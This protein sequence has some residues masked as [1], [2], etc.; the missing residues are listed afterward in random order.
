VDASKPT[1]DEP[2][3]APVL[4]TDREAARLCGISRASWHRLRAAGRLPPV[5]RLG[6]SCR[7]RRAELLAWVDAGCPDSRVWSAMV[8]S[9][10]R[11]PR[12]VS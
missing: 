2:V 4:I 8:A 12:V 5:V 7:W 9:G 10:R 11:L 3:P 1:P 6:R